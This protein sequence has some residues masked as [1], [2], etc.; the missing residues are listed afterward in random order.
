MVD[1][2]MRPDNSL[3]LVETVGGPWLD[4][5][6]RGGRGHIWGGDAWSMF[7]KAITEMLQTASR[8]RSCEKQRVTEELKKAQP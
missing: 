4:G 2:G 7:V 5:S 3:G 6:R 1:I 8:T